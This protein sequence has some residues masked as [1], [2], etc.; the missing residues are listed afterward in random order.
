MKI[1]IDATP[2]AHGRRAIRRHSKNLVEALLRRDLDN[3][4][5][6]LYIDWHRRRDRYVQ[7]PKDRQVKEFVIPVPARLV[8][9]LWRR[10]G[11]PLAEWVAGNLDVFYATDLYFPPSL[12]AVVLGSVRGIAYYTIKEK[13]DPKEVALLIDGLT[14]TL[15]HADYLL[16]VSCSTREE[17]ITRLNVPR[18]RIYVVHHGIDPRFKKLEDRDSLSK[19]LVQKLG[20]SSPYILYVGVIGHHKNI[21]GL[22]KAFSILYSN[23]TDVPLVL[24]GPPGSAWYQAKNWIKEQRLENLVHLTGLVDQD[25]NEL[26]DLYNGACLFVFPSFY[27]GWSAPPLE[28][29]TCGIPVITSNCFSLPETVGDAAIMVD[30]NG[31]ESLAFEMERVLSDEDFRMTLIEKGFNHV[32]HYTWD[33][34]AKKFIEVFDDIHSRGPWKRQK[35]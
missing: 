4:Y 7:I 15:K 1:V 32:A 11:L 14:Y 29:M 26:N 33:E 10:V 20:F 22:L 34:A 3:K 35:N 13:L 12:Q 2:V 9:S 23:G 8:K 19:R 28:A 30:P 25:S 27:E 16:A 6:L 18:D 31:I 17:M 5:G 24:V 21:M